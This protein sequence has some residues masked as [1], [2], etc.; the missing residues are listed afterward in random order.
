MQGNLENIQG[1]VFRNL[2]QAIQKAAAR[3]LE[4]IDAA[5]DLEDLRTPPCGCLVFSGIRRNFG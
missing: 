4:I 1:K 3:K 5:G 2:P